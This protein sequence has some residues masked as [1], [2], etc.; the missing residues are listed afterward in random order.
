MLDVVV[1]QAYNHL[2][3]EL[4]HFH[5]FW[6]CWLCIFGVWEGDRRIRLLVQSEV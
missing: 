2:P 6:H 4:V 5:T 3:W 1:R